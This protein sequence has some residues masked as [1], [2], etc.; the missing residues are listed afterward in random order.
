MNSSCV[1]RPKPSAMLA[2]TDSE[3][4][5]ICAVRALIE[6]EGR[7]F[8]AVEDRLRPLSRTLPEL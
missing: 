4:S 1:A 3:E 6:G 7:L 8:R 2:I 5:L